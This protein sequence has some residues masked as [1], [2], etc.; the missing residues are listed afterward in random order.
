MAA[1][2]RLACQL[3]QSPEN[4]LEGLRESR[5]S[6]VLRPEVLASLVEFHGQA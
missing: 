3:A 5:P 2:Y 1:A 6:I 4:V